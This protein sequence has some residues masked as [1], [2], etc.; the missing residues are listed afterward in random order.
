MVGVVNFIF[1]PVSFGVPNVK[2]GKTQENGVEPRNEYRHAVL[3]SMNVV[4]FKGKL[5]NASTSA[6]HI[7]RQAVVC[8]C[9]L[10][11]SSTTYPSHGPPDQ[12]S[13]QRLLTYVVSSIESCVSW[14]SRESSVIFTPCNSQVIPQDPS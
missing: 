6:L 11:I 5:K 8:E 14:G 2:Q 1:Y 4:Y 7:G 10:F 12:S 9:K 3:S 13:P